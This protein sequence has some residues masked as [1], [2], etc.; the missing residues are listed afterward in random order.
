MGKLFQ[1]QASAPRFAYDS[2][3]KF[4]S[5]WMRGTNFF[6]ISSLYVETKLSQKCIRLKLFFARSQTNQRGPERRA[7]L[8]GRR[9][10]M[11]ISVSCSVLFFILAGLKEIGG[12]YLARLRLRREASPGGRR[13]LWKT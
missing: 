7:R 10:Q 13:R 12:G 9:G 1:R 2:R 5:I 8:T 11:L 4:G 6:S 3:F